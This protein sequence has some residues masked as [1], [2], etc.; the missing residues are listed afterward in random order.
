MGILKM[1]F[2]G[3]RGAS[4]GGRGGFSGGRGGRGGF[5]AGGRG[6]M[7]P[8]DQVV[9]IAT[10]MHS[11]PGTPTL[12]FC[13]STLTNQVPF[14]CRLFRENKTELGKVDEIMGP[15]NE[16]YFS[17]TPSEGINASSLK[18]GEVIYA[19]PTSLK[20]LQIFLPRP[21]KSEKKPTSR[22]GATGGRG[23]AAGGRGRGGSAG[24]RGGR[25]GARGGAAKT[26]VTP[27][28]FEGV[29][30][31]RGKNE[32]LATRNLVPGESVYG[33]KRMTAE[34]EGEKVEYRIW[35][36]FRSK[37][38]AAIVGGLGEF[39]IKPGSKV[40][41]LGAASGTTVS[42]ISDLVGPEGIVYAVEFSHRPGRD[43]TNMSKRRPNIVPIVEDARMPLKY[44]MVVGMVDCIFSDV[45]QRD[46]TRIVLENAN[47]FLKPKGW[48][49]V[50][51][52][53]AC[54]DSTATPE[55]VYLM[56]QN[57]LKAG[58]VSL[59]EQ[60]TLEPYHRDHALITGVFRKKK[61]E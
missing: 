39:P 22:G 45:A 53:A 29:F 2:R 26:L 27:H 49:M 28:A 59:K 57:V 43:L 16:V 41:Y 1:S 42:H 60:L 50:S 12:F 4:S 17:A 6:P 33:E 3:G 56:E 52:K 58:K 38:G 19:D 55:A 48:V 47:L 23:G 24:G 54:V 10:F 51:V 44:R 21:A 32:S 37:V 30:V 20:D 13:K 11:V 36:P 35:N 46:Q 15:I 5:G 8:P 14:Y 61:S 31:V 7:G 18:S 25:G 40:L 34:I 9:P